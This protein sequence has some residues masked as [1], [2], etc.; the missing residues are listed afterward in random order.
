MSMQKKF[1]KYYPNIF[2]LNRKALKIQHAYYKI[3]AG[4]RKGISAKYNTPLNS[5]RVQFKPKYGLNE[6]GGVGVARK[7]LKSPTSYSKLSALSTVN[8]SNSKSSGKLLLMT[9]VQ[10]KEN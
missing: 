10:N 7:L 8:N 6:L 1:M 2:I 3:K 4:V 9:D 5:S